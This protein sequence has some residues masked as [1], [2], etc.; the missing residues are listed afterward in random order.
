MYEDEE[1]EIFDSQ[2]YTQ[3]VIEE[4]DDDE[5]EENQEVPVFLCASCGFM[6]DFANPPKGYLPFDNYIYEG[7]DNK[8]KCPKCG[9]KVDFQVIN[10]KKYEELM[11]KALKKQEEKQKK[12]EKEKEKQ[13]EKEKSKRID[14]IKDDLKDLLSDL[15]DRLFSG[16][17]T[18]KRFV[19]I[20]MNLSAKIVDRYGK[21]VG[22]RS[23][24]LKDELYD[25][26]DDI[27]RVYKVQEKA[28]DILSEMQEDINEDELYQAEQAYY[29]ED[30]KFSM[31]EYEYKQR[32]KEY[33]SMDKQ[34]A[35]E[36]Y[37]KEL[38]EKYQSRRLELIRR[39][40]ERQEKKKL[41]DIL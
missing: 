18:P 34:I 30:D 38:E 19:A 6:Y 15:K 33:E 37:K 35:R 40:E 20:Y 21:K 3:E 9:R 14:Q 36:E 16:E 2:R 31:P 41:R 24:D 11:K 17:I 22:I 39:A 8:V 32:L 23:Y 29:L 26:A 1:E 5:Q 7:S 10:R 4:P 27:L 28:E 12:L 13:E 25:F